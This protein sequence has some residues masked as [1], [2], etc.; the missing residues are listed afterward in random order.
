MVPARQP[1][2]RRSTPRRRRDED[3]S[4]SLACGPRGV[5]EGLSVTGFDARMQTLH[6][7]ERRQHG[8]LLPG[9]QIRGMLARQRQ[10]AVD[11]AEVL[12]VRVAG[13]L[14]PQA[15][16]AVGPGNA[17]PTDRDAV[18]ELLRI[19]RMDLYALAKDLAQTLFRRHGREFKRVGT[20][21]IAADDHA[22]AGLAVSGGGVTDARDRQIA[23]GYP[24]VDMLILLP[25]FALELQAGLERGSVWYRADRVAHRLTGGHV[26][27]AQN[28]QRDCADAPVGLGNAR[29]SVDAAGVGIGHRDALV[30][31]IDFGD[32]GV[33]PHHV[34]DLAI[35]RH[36]DLV[37][38]PN[39]LKDRRLELV[40]RAAGDGAPQLRA[41]QFVPV[42]RHRGHWLR[43]EPTPGIDRI[44]AAIAR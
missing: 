4:T 6:G 42:E 30:A 41:Q 16:T 28:G 5:D 38:A 3:G 29:R 2:R 26:D 27:L 14:R 37:H 25:E 39:G 7:V 12:V 13:L 23:V 24:A 11:L 35:D 36:R 44:A 21:D 15:V 22:L 10:A 1:G 20:E 31:L 8:T 40:V 32:L 43:H 17:V 34:L 9:R 18:L 33:E 19:L